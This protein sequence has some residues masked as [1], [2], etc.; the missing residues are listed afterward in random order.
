M[1]PSPPPLDRKLRAEHHHGRIRH[2]GLAMWV[3]V[4][5]YAASAMAVGAPASARSAGPA[6][7]QP[8]TGHASTAP[9]YGVAH[10]VPATRSDVPLGP[11]E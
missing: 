2:L 5:L 6:S 7:P 8:P 9:A 11:A 3:L 1:P 10:A 4:I